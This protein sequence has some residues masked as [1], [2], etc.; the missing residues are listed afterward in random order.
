M[1]QKT[2]TNGIAGLKKYDVRVTG[3]VFMLYCL[4]G[5]GAFGI[6]EDDPRSRSGD[7]S[8]AADYLSCH[9]GVPDKQ[10]CR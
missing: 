2:G 3:I 7:D 1:E 8:D 5:A 6:E 4:V 10:Y 9:M